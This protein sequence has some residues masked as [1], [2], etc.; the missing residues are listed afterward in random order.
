M[1]TVIHT[2]L[3]LFIVS[4]EEKKKKVFSLRT[5]TVLR[6]SDFEQRRISQNSLADGALLFGIS[7]K[8]MKV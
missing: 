7:I 6:H 8:I 3:Y 2:I 1:K 5:K 4:R